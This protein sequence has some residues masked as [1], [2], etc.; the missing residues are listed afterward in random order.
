[1]NNE[2]GYDTKNCI[3][4]VFPVYFQCIS[5]VFLVYHSGSNGCQSLEGASRSLQPLSQAIRSLTTN[6]WFFLQFLIELYKYTNVHPLSQAIRSLTA[7]LFC[8]SFS[9]FCCISM[10]LFNYKSDII[11]KHISSKPGRKSDQQRE[12]IPAASLKWKHK[13]QMP[14]D[15]HFIPFVTQTLDNTIIQ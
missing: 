1:M 13:Q 9:F 10:V 4:S 15:T 6:W 3:S 2:E 5:S 12:R 7:N 8:F 11:R 14:N